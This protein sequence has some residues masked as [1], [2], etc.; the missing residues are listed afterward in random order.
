[1][2][3]KLN[4]ALIRSARAAAAGLALALLSVPSVSVGA[5]VGPIMDPVIQP[6]PAYFDSGRPITEQPIAVPAGKSL[7]VPLTASDADGDPLR[8]IAAAGNPRI[9]PGLIQKAPALKLTVDYGSGT[10]EMVFLLFKDLAPNT[11]RN[12]IGLVNAHYYDGLK[13]H[14]II[15][16]FMAQGGD[17]AGTGSGVPPFQSDDE[18]NPSAIFT[19]RGQLAMAN[20]G[21]DT[22]GTQFFVTFA[23]QRHLD[24][25]HTIFGQLV[26]G[27]DT[28]AN[29][30]SK[31][32]PGG[33]PTETVTITKAEMIMDQQD[34]VLR[35]GAAP[36]NLVP[37][38][39]FVTVRCYDDRGGYFTRAFEPLSEADTSNSRPY[40]TPIP[41][42]YANPGQH[43]QIPLR[44]ID[45]EG[46]VIYYAAAYADFFP[47]GEEIPFNA[48]INGRVVTVSP[49][50]PF[51]GPVNIKV[52]VSAVADYS[53]WNAGW[54][55]QIV[56]I[57][58]GEQPITGVGRNVGGQANV[59]IAGAL[60][61]NFAHPDATRTP[62][63][64]GAKINWGDGSDLTDG[65]ISQPYANKVFYVTGNH[66]YTVPGQF[67]ITVTVTSDKGLRQKVE[68]YANIAP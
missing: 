60:V 41:D 51:E 27:W 15:Q 21:D 2:S 12:I 38:K 67:P 25:Q 20:S 63:T 53:G 23:P 65:V 16:K 29:I 39:G 26:R 5:N 43:V 18:F 24:F 62:G 48:D 14:R 8:W 10:G 30:E 22:N 44:G 50:S 52:G 66:T 3:L 28:L 61:A 9:I 37:W 11:V 35:L 49:K 32:T 68:A 6:Y 4:V 40:L 47:P 64:F 13:F 58:Y 34:A 55:T 1:M 45:L 33:T 19:G 31:G 42:F 46:D 36:S 54:D 56:R 59:P 57:C 17:K 7:L